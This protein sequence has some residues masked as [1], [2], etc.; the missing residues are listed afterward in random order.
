MSSTWNKLQQKVFQRFLAQNFILYNISK[1][2]LNPFMEKC[3][4]FQF[5]WC[6]FRLRGSLATSMVSIGL[7]IMDSNAALF[8]YPIQKINKNIELRKS[9]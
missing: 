2:D 9:V 6:T 7:L 3:L 1:I 8:H 4:N 5:I